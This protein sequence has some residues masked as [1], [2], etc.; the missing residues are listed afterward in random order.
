MLTWAEYYEGDKEYEIGT[1]LVFGGEKEVTE[2]T[3]HK[4]TRVA[5][6]VSD[7]K[8]IYNEPKNVPV[9]KRWLH[10]KEKFQM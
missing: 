1:V 7:S 4:T 9:L 2:S 6:V 3:E 5:G 10:C 8:C